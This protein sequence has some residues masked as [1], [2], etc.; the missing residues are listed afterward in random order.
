MAEK[1]YLATG[2]DRSGPFT[3]EELAT[4]PS[5]TANSLVWKGGMSE[6]AR[7][8]QVADVAALLPLPALPREQS[9][10]TSY[11][12]ADPTPD[13][14]TAL[15]SDEDFI[16]CNPRLPRMAQLVCVYGILI[17]PA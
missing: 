4:Q 12:S 1:Y 6:W 15:T 14:P 17:N 16:L 7:A 10:D 5:L 8:E 13:R 3:L 2:S 9:Q 11:Q